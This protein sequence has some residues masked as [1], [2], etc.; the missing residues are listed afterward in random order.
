MTVERPLQPWAIDAAEMFDYAIRA[1][2]HLLLDA[3][4]TASEKPG[5]YE[6]TLNDVVAHPRAREIL[7]CVT[8]MA[9]GGYLEYYRGDTEAA[10][11][12]IEREL[13]IAEDLQDPQARI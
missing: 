4:V 5:Y 13:S 1:K 8:R 10:G 7:D 12:T 9:L 11:W 3:A 6:C 2:A